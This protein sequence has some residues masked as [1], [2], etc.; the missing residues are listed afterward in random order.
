MLTDRLIHPETAPKAICFAKD[1]DELVGQQQVKVVS[2]HAG[3]WLRQ[4]ALA[5]QG[6]ARA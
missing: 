5:C 4:K 3:W 1:I 2:R 6:K